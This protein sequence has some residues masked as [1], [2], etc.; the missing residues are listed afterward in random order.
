M[1]NT[2]YDTT[3]DKINELQQLKGTTE[4]KLHQNISD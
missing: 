3:E 1:V 2:K 4:S